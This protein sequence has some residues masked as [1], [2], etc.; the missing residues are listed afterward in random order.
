MRVLNLKLSIP[1]VAVLATG[2]AAAVMVATVS[3]APVAQAKTGY[4][5]DCTGC[6]SAG[7]SVT[8]TAAA[9]QLPGASY[10]VALAFTGGSSPNAFWISG[11]GVNVT[12]SSAT[13]ATMTAPATAG[14]YTYTVWVRSGVVASTTYSITVAAAPTTTTPPVTTTTTPPV[15]TTTEPPTTV[16]P[17][18]EPVTTSIISSLSPDHG[19]AGDKVTIRGANFGK[20]GVVKFGAGEAKVKS[21]SSTKIEVKVPSNFIVRVKSDDHSSQPVWY[22][23]DDKSA[24]VT[25]TPKDAAA[26]N[27][28]AFSVESDHDHGDDHGDD[29]HKEKSRH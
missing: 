10:T 9:T 24:M 11:N 26:S 17:T 7:G 16:E 2:L 18:K 6:H 25:V 5:E 8:A 20:A 3:P 12:G 29:G 13:S 22:R 28:V 1:K 21:W 15:T 4:T 19:E 14:T 27:A 23:H